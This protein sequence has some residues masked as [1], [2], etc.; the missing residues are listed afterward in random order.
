M[1][2]NEGMFQHVS[3]TVSNQRAVS[4]GVL[5]ACVLR[6]WFFSHIY[7]PLG[8]LCAEQCEQLSEVVLF[9]CLPKPLDLAE[10]VWFDLK[11]NRV[12]WCMF[13][14]RVARL[15]FK[16]ARNIAD[17]DQDRPAISVCLPIAKNGP[18]CPQHSA[19][20]LGLH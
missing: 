8:F 19:L 7:N 14:Q 3:R 15:K 20:V 1:V 6:I 2:V 18:D 11:L 5:T 13:H 9:P 12:F 16:I 4:N 17:S 10:R